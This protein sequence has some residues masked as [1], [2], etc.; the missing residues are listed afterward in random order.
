MSMVIS[1]PQEIL[2][3]VAE[4]TRGVNITVLS[5]ATIIKLLRTWWV[6]ETALSMALADTNQFLD[7]RVQISWDLYEVSQTAI[8]SQY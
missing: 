6:Y 1:Y 7:N 2:F 3:L 5:F 8:V 4:Q